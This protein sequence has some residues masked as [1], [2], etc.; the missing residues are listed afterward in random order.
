[1]PAWRVDSKGRDA[2]AGVDQLV[3]V[4]GGSTSK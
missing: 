3:G 1:M 2:E 4:R